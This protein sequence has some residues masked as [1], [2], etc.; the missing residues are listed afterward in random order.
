MCAKVTR[1][2][3][4]SLL[5]INIWGLSR[6][7]TPKK[8]KYWYLS[9][10]IYIKSEFETIAITIPAICSLALQT[11]SH[12]S[13]KTWVKLKLTILQYRTSLIPVL[14][15]PLMDYLFKK[16]SLSLGTLALPDLPHFQTPK[17]LMVCYTV[18]KSV[19]KM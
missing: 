5:H 7:K 11:N 17:T 4:P 12:P 2:Q 8:E 15:H 1:S 3:T 13:R 14:P 10:H 9:I 16:F 6:K 18:K 19:S